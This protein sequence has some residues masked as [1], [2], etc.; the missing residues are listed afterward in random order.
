MKKED[1]YVIQGLHTTKRLLDKGLQT[2]ERAKY[3]KEAQA[4]IQKLIETRNRK[5]YKY[6]RK[7]APPSLI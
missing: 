6:Y 3:L 2:G 4:E 7:V 1:D 5:L